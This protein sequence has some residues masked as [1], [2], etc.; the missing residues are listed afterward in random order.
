MAAV[1]VPFD[2]LVLCMDYIGAVVT[3]VWLLL[4]CHVAYGNLECF[5]VAPNS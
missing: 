3:I 2:L 4:M 1:G 5:S